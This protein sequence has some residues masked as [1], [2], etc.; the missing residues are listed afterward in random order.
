MYFSIF[1]N[2]NVSKLFSI[3]TYLSAHINPLLINSIT[4]KADSSDL[5]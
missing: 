1:Y 5:I 4:Q 2:K 3:S